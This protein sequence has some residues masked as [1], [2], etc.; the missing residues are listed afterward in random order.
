MTIET[1]FSL[2]ETVFFMEGNSIRSGQVTSIILEVNK[3]KQINRYYNSDSQNIYYENKLFSSK[4]E[5]LN[6]L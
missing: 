1:K 2:K 3:D 5:L 4:K 6:S